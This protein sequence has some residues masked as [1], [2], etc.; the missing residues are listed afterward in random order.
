MCGPS[1]STTQRIHRLSLPTPKGTLVVLHLKLTRFT[2]LCK[3]L[4]SRQS[5]WHWD[6][7]HSPPPLFSR[8]ENYIIS[9]WKLKVSKRTVKICPTSSGFQMHYCKWYLF[10]VIGNYK[11]GNYNS[12]IYPEGS[13]SLVGPVFSCV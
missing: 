4:I 10:L 12:G 3:T 6:P 8:T 5:R 13:E 7:L 9:N 2:W 1:G 11:S